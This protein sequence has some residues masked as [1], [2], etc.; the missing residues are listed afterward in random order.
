MR[1]GATSVC[2]ERDVQ[3][4][5]TVSQLHE[6]GVARAVAAVA[7]G[8]ATGAALRW[9]VGRALVGEPAEWPWAT[10]AVNVLG[11]LAIGIASVVVTRGSLRWDGLV[12]GLLGGFTTMSSFAVELND[13]VDAGRPSIAGMSA[14]TTLLTGIAAVHLGAVATR[15]L[16]SGDTDVRID[17]DDASGDGAT[18][19]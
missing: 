3:V 6:R 18:A 12:T 16:G 19:P 1:N 13:L 4:F 15:R 10:F 5:P 2:Y 8:G 11:C 14:L 9:A 7:G 17:A